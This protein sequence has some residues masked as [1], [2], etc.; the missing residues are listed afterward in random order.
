[1]ENIQTQTER[2]T[3]EEAADRELRE[4]RNQEHLDRMQQQATNIAKLEQEIADLKD[5]LKQYKDLLKCEQNALMNMARTGVTEQ[6]TLKLEPGEEPQHC[7]ECSDPEWWT[8][9]TNEL[10]GLTQ[11]EHERVAE[12]FK[13]C[14]DLCAWLG[15]DF[16]DKIS[17]FG[18]KF[19]EKLSNAVNA[20]AG[21]PDIY[22]HDAPAPK[23]PK[24]A[25]KE[26][27]SL[28][29]ERNDLEVSA[30]LDEI[31]TMLDAIEYEYATETL[32]GIRDWVQENQCYTYKQ[33]EAVA[34]IR[35][36]PTPGVLK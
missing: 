14:G 20:L 22:Q 4:A 7:E 1:M 33:Y 12:H 18:E 21:L 35:E 3:A 6:L 34:N 27:S 32:E 13:T 19:R 25:T 2:E 16:R 30:F 36:N 5:K 8:H 29:V 10:P 11:R 31:E 28:E 9:P 23:E 15:D 24:P 17:G 26:E